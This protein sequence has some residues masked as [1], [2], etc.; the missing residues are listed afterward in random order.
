MPVVPQTIVHRLAECFSE[1]GIL[2]PEN[3]D[4][5]FTKCSS[6]CCHASLFGTV[7]LLTICIGCTVKV[8]FDDATAL[9]HLE[10]ESNGGVN[11]V[12]KICQLFRNIVKGNGLANSNVTR[13]DI[14]EHVAFVLS[15]LGSFQS[16]NKFVN[17]L[18][19]LGRR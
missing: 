13:V 16:T 10:A 12:Q 11:V 14:I 9:Q 2:P 19:A 1:Q 15:Q 7:Q 3:S 8:L 5:S 4:L 18:L 17:C 6:C